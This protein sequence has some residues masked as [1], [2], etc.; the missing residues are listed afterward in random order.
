MAGNVWEWVGEP[1][2]PVAEN[3]HVLHGGRFGL[4]RDIAYRQ[5]AAADDLRFS[6]YAGVRCAADP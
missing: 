5:T 6:E 3:L 1:Y 2:A 4:L